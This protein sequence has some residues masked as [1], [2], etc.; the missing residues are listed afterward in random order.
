MKSINFKSTYGIQDLRKI[1][2]RKINENLKS[3]IITNG[4]NCK[5]LEKLICKKTGSK[6]AVVCNNGTSA[7]MMALNA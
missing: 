7:L 5:K 1:N 2:F 4:K 6:F 3:D